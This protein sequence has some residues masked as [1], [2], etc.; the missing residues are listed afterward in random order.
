M[1]ACQLRL[2]SLAFS[3]AKTSRRRRLIGAQ[4]L[5]LC[6]IFQRPV[7]VRACVYVCTPVPSTKSR[8]RDLIILSVLLKAFDRVVP[9]IQRTRPTHLS[10]PGLLSGSELEL[11][12]KNQA[13]CYFHIAAN[14][15]LLSSFFFFLN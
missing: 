8:L 13:H 2:C 9:P 6:P 3:P 4:A 1:A 11:A 15:P 14:A 5:P 7:C 10:T 12:S